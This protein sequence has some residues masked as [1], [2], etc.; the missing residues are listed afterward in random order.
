[1]LNIHTHTFHHPEAINIRS[2]QLTGDIPS[3]VGKLSLLEE[4]EARGNRLDGTIPTEIAKLSYLKVLSIRENL[5]TGTIPIEIGA[6]T[7]LEVLQLRQNLLVSTIPT[8]IGLLTMLTDMNI[9]DNRMT[10]EVFPTEIFRLSNLRYMSMGNSA[11][12]RGNTFWGTIPTSIAFMTNLGESGL[13][14]FS[15]RS[16]L[17]V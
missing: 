17:H 12:E 11:L 3:D 14:S 15:S 5:I 2:N 4:L 1:M 16:F 10:G 6:L 7:A 13:S 8:E 9:R